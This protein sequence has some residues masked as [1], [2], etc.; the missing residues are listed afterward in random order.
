MIKNKEKFQEAMKA[1]KDE[2]RSRQFMVCPICNTGI[3]GG[4][5]YYSCDNEKCDAYDSR[6]M[7]NCEICNRR[8]INCCC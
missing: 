7:C 4:I 1:L 8:L 6:V 2:G 5:I 3:F